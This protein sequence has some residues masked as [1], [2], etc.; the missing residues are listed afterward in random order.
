MQ[1]LGMVMP[2]H[3]PSGMA[4]ST[5]QDAWDME[6]PL[7]Q[8]SELSELADEFPSPNESSQFD[9]SFQFNESSRFNDSNGSCLD[10]PPSSDELLLNKSTD[11]PGD[12]GGQGGNPEVAGRC[13]RGGKAK[14]SWS[15]RN[16][17]DILESD[18]LEELNT[19]GDLGVE[20]RF[21]VTQAEPLPEDQALGWKGNLFLS[22][23]SSCCRIVQSGT[24]H[25]VDFDLGAVR[26]ILHQV[27]TSGHSPINP[28][29]V[30]LGSAPTQIKTPTELERWY[31]L[32]TMKGF[33][34]VCMDLENKESAIHFSYMISAIQFV[35]KII[36]CAPF[37]FLA[38][39]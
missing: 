27:M 24:S 37:S 10:G 28:Y 8:L 1:N 22:R 39:F 32:E 7:T 31:E 19:A 15:S 21:E 26:H 20:R 25:T 30:S 23:I 14:R 9:K 35:S 38:C 33:L 2:P 17:G 3:V 4:S 5:T 12:Q 11:P 34:H 16:K 13:K 18:E 29:Q 6:S 36:V